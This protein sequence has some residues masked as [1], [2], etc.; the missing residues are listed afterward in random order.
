[1]LYTLLA[2]TVA[3]V[4]V[5]IIYRALKMLWFTSWFMGWIRGMFGLSLLV[6]AIAVGAISYDIYSYKQILSEQPVATINFDVIEEQYFVAILVDAKTGKQQRFNL[7]GD[8][9]QLDARIIKWKG[10]FSSFGIKPAYRLDRL[11]GRYYDIEKET[12]GKRSVFSIAAMPYQIDVWRLLNE[13]AKWFPVIDARYGSA[14]YLP[15]KK[16]ALYEISLSNTGLVAR[17]LNDVASKAVAEW[18]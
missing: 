13:H 1:M 5:F 7:H 15:M 6:A 4:A 2:L 12:T 18:N 14:T 3:I 11:S 16:D 9:W 10:Y 8:Q 17:P